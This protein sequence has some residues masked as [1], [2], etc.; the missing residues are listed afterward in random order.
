MSGQT[1][2]YIRVSSLLQNTDRQL[3]GVATDRIFEDKLSGKDTN[4]PQLQEMLSFIREGDTVLVHS[5]DRLG[6]NLDDLRN[7]VNGM[8]SRGITVK[9]VK[10]NLTFS[11]GENNIFSELML[12]MLASFAQFERSLSKERQ[13]EGV[14]IAKANG[15]YAGKG[16]KQE[17]TEERIAELRSRVAAGEPKAKIAAVMGISRDTLYRYL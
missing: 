7:L 2:G 8:V 6:R 12:N 11:S 1:V 17:M 13:R 3:D 15:V 14:Q 4:R 5:L 16:R 9:F 10:E